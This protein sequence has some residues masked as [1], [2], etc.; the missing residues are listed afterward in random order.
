MSSENTLWVFKKIVCQNLVWCKI[1]LSFLLLLFLL[2]DDEDTFKILI[3]TDI[4]LGYL[5]KDAI[6]GNDTYNTLEEILKHAKTEQVH[7]MNVI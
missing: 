4:H 6:R 5:E 7:I 1:T 3:S 2:R